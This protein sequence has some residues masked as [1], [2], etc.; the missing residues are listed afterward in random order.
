MPRVPVIDKL[1][2]LVPSRSPMTS[3]KGR[4]PLHPLGR[5][6]HLLSKVSVIVIVHFLP[7]DS[8]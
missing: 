4:E 5:S 2:V 8:G 6:P 1:Q 3:F 7:G